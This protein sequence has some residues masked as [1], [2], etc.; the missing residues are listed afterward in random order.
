MV[1]T[2]YQPPPL[3]F[4]PWSINAWLRSISS[5]LAEEEGKHS[6][7]TPTP[8][9]TSTIAS[10]TLTSQETGSGSHLP[11]PLTHAF[12]QQLAQSLAPRHPHPI[13]ITPPSPSDDLSSRHLLPQSRKRKRNP[14]L[15]ASFVPASP[16][17]DEMEEGPQTPNTKRTTSSKLRQT[18]DAVSE[19]LKECGMLYEDEDA[20]GR[21]PELQH[22]IST[23]VAPL[24]DSAVKSRSPGHFRDIYHTYANSN[25]GT[26]L[27]HILP[28]MIKDVFGATSTESAMSS[29]SSLDKQGEGDGT[30]DEEA[31]SQIQE[32]HKLGLFVTLDTGF[33][34]GLMPIEGR[35]LEL[36]P[37]AEAKSEKW[38]LEN[39]KP[40][41][42]FGFQRKCL[43]LPKGI[44]FPEE[45][46][47]LLEVSPYMYQPFFIIEGKSGNGNPIKV[48]NQARR[49]GATLVHAARQLR[50][51][52]RLGGE[53][54][55]PAVDDFRADLSTIV[56]SAT[57]TFEAFYVWIHWAEVSSCGR[58]E[59]HMNVIDGV[60]VTAR[61]VLEKSRR[62]SHNI[63]WWGLTQR[64]QEVDELHTALIRQQG[65]KEE[66]ASPSK[67][68][69]I[70]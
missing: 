24:R 50:Q 39:S 63:L 47:V 67:K 15:I 8:A 32:W 44:R 53:G 56:F 62:W 5:A 58:V 69:R 21:H 25:E 52:A 27:H 13:P 57:L 28:L 51:K 12:L 65:L 38:G 14:S 66:K 4:T 30:D 3:P 43:P 37:K 54:H 11:L 10:E 20:F 35:G 2:T 22:F 55:T 7:G 46:K 61:D 31:E 18:E 40:D 34:R 19:K 48:R 6:G 36:L 1:T 64:R 68:Q 29:T 16:Q 23:H 60:L 49:G 9:S 59:Y 17:C 45:I 42:T 33:Q 41:R 26:Y 70:E